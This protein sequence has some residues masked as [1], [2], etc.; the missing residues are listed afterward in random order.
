MA[1]AEN[2]S[3]HRKSIAWQKGMQLAKAVYLLTQS[4]PP[5]ERFGITNQLRRASVSIPSNIAEGKGRLSVGELI[6][7][8]GVARGST[9]EVQ[10]QLE[11]ASMLGYGSKEAIESADALTQEIVKILNA[12]IATLRTRLAKKKPN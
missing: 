10:T 8:L 5:E 2:V 1:K 11:L 6:Q 7:F 4:F 12:T 3:S 9:L